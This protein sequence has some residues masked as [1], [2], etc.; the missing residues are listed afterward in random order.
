M[1]RSRTSSRTEVPWEAFVALMADYIESEGKPRDWAE[2]VA[3]LWME[4]W[5]YHH[6]AS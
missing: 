1:P 5:E 2:Q 3:E 6:A 4:Y